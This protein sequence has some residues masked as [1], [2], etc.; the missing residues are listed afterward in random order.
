LPA[1]LGYQVTPKELHP[2]ESPYDFYGA[3]A[4]PS[5]GVAGDVLTLM[6]DNRAWSATGAMY[7][8]PVSVPFA[9]DFT[10]TSSHAGD[11]NPPADAMTFF[12]AKAEGG[13]E[14]APVSRDQQGAP[15]DGTGYAV[16]LN[17]WTQSV[18]L[19]DGDWEAIGDVLGFNT[20][21]DG[22]PVAVRVEVHA[23]EVVVLW[24]GEELLREAVDV[25][26]S[27]EH[28]GFS[29]ATGAYTIDYQIQDVAYESL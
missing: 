4:A 1:N 11:E 10:V 12:F 8:S 9:V 16:E 3:G 5:C 13:Y 22:V 6:P 7:R 29:A 26:T 25:D 21:T 24:D 19:R 17:V 2:S 18:A 27:H 14:T 28:V 20:F 23:D 15:A